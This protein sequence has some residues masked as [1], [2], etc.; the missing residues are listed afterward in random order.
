MTK[1]EFLAFGRPLH[2]MSLLKGRKTG[3]HKRQGGV[4]NNCRLEDQQ[5]WRLKCGNVR[6]RMK[7]EPLCIYTAASCIASLH[8]LLLLQTPEP[9]R[10]QPGQAPSC[11]SAV[12]SKF[13]PETSNLQSECTACWKMYSQAR[14]VEYITKDCPSCAKVVITVAPGIGYSAAG[15]ALKQSQPSWFPL[16]LA[17]LLLVAAE[18]PIPG[19]TLITTLANDGHSSLTS[20]KQGWIAL[21]P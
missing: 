13:K 9:I 6:K 12:P 16:I 7:N 20:H 4:G 3:L 2:E 1:N 14:I 15:A 11:Q 17:L 21:K 19:A 5:T 8:F 10:E 18:Y